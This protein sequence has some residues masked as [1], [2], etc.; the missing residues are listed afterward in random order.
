MYCLSVC[1]Y[2][3]AQSFAVTTSKWPQKYNHIFY[4]WRRRRRRGGGEGACPKSLCT[5]FVLQKSRTI[6]ILFLTNF[7]EP[8][9]LDSIYCPMESRIKSIVH[10]TVQFQSPGFVPIPRYAYV[11]KALPVN[12]LHNCLGYLHFTF[13][14]GFPKSPRYSYCKR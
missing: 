10:S 3:S 5:C 4:R 14:N 1:C 2:A 12:D 6:S 7:L 11:P 9:Q 8:L 13:R